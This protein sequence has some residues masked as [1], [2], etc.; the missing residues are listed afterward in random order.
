MNIYISADIGGMRFDLS[1]LQAIGGSPVVTIRR[2]PLDDWQQLQ[3][4]LFDRLVGGML[5]LSMCPILLLVALIIR[6][7]SSGPILFRQ[8]RMGLNNRVF[9]VYKFRS[10]ADDSDPTSL[11]GARQAKRSDPRLTRVGKYLR[12][13]SID[14]LPQLLN[15]MKGEMSL[16]GPR[17][18]PL[19]TGV[20]DQLFHEVVD[21]YAERHRV[22]PGI[23]GWAQV[24]G[25]RGETIVPEQI[26]QRVAHDLHYIDNWS[27]VLD[28]RILLLTIAREIIS[29]KAF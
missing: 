22:L 20:G 9:I 15:V 27:L 1:D 17:P 26:E 24:N 10:M 19:N 28:I 12:R 6:L 18:H 4:A 21:N 16:V 2:R 8:P 13:Y 23:T 5:L 3:K 29:E 7:D 25:W 14:E 11:Y